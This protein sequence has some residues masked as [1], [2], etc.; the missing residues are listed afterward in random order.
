MTKSLIDLQKVRYFFSHEEAL[1]AP[2]R[3]SR[4]AMVESTNGRYRWILDFDPNPMLQNPSPLEGLEIQVQVQNFM[5]FVDF[6]SPKIQ[7]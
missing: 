3:C 5:D 2:C 1:A 7:S 6:A 4:C